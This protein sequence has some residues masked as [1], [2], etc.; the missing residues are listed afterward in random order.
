M[1]FPAQG[2]VLSLFDSSVL[3]GPQGQTAH[4]ATAGAS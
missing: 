4:P 3:N 1:G 2:C